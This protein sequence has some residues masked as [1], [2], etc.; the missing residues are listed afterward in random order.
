MS[1]EPRRGRAVDGRL[2]LPRELRARLLAGELVRLTLSGHEPCSLEPGATYWLSPRRWLEIT[3]V[4]RD[5]RMDWVLRYTLH[6]RRDR[7]RLL[8][9]NPHAVD[10]DT[11]RASYDDYGTPVAPTR[12]VIEEAR[13]DGAYTSASVF[14]LG[15][16][17]EAVDDEF[18][19]RDR[20]ARDV[21]AANAKKARAHRDRSRAGTEANRLTEG[22]MQAKPDAA[23]AVARRAA[24]AERR[25]EKE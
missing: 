5:S 7:A 15:E 14:A 23:R 10:F 13:E 17:G 21:D 16:V 22:L 24:R 6:D 9:R 2:V 18:L 3:K 12:R 8:R 19:A 20:L 25:L 11:I 4:T 1:D